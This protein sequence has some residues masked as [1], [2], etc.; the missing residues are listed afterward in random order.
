MAGTRSHPCTCFRVERM[1][2]STFRTTTGER[3][4]EIDSQQLDA[5]GLFP[6][7]AWVNQSE[8]CLSILHSTGGTA[9]PPARR[10]N[11]AARHAQKRQFLVFSTT[12]Y[13]VQSRTE[14]AGG[15]SR[16]SARKIRDNRL[17]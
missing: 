4:R 5:T 11:I 16:E 8:R 10:G 6:R 9:L 15:G 14:G 12:A 17:E 1:K 2:I 7:P 13:T 3:K